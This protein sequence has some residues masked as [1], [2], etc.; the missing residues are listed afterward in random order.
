LYGYAQALKD[1]AQHPHDLKAY[2]EH[3]LFLGGIVHP[4]QF[5]WHFKKVITMSEKRVAILNEK[6]PQKEALA[7]GPYIHYA[8][9]LLAAKT[10]NALKMELGKVLLVYPFHSM[11]GVEAGFEENLLIEE[12][13]KVAPGFDTVL[14]SLY[15]LD[16]QQEL[17]VKP[18][19]EAGFRV[20]TAGHKFDRLFVNRQ[21]SHIELADV[22]MSNGMG[23]QTGFCV[24][25]NKPHY[26]FKQEVVQK[27]KS[28]KEEARHASRNNASVKD[29]VKKE[30]EFF[31]DLF[32]EFQDYIS[33]E[34]Y[35]ATAEYWGFKAL[36]TPAELRRF[37]S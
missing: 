10:F 20:I 15:Y 29:A 23:T 5:Y 2:F 28:A 16:A 27:S 8:K 35:E 14:V 12:I 11:K 13:K 30:R 17:R 21:R 34:Q 32:S 1:Y 33:P 22:T 18:Y 24:L 9:S 19:Q 6:L 25:L 26:I 31:A 7:V 36:K 4:D 3:G 37:L